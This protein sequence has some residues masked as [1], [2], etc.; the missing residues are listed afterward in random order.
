MAVY[1]GEEKT[2]EGAVL[3]IDSHMWMDGMEEVHAVVWNRETHK[4]ES[5]QIGY[6]GIDGTNLAG[7]RADVDANRETVLDMMRTFKVEAFGAFARSVVEYKTAIRKG[8]KAVVTRGR[9]VPKGT[10]LEVFWVGERQ[11]YRSRQYD[12][13]NETETV[14]G[15]YD[16]DGNKVWIKVEYLKAIDPIKSP[17]AKER[18]KFINEYVKDRVRKLGVNV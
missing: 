12:W 17:N 14:A 3:K 8:R 1:F 9:K 5:V 13:M 15:C 7:G 18:K 2:F 11:T 10:E 16:K 4:T 6:Y